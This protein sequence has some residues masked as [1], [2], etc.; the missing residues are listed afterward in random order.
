MLRPASP[1]LALAACSAVLLAACATVGAAGGAVNGTAGAGAAGL[2]PLAGA[3]FGAVIGEAPDFGIGW[4]DG[5]RDLEGP[6]RMAELGFDFTVPYVGPGS[7][8]DLA[9]YLARVEEAGLGI[10]LEVPRAQALARGTPLADYI[11]RH[12]GSPSLLGWYLF[13]EPE[14][15]PSSRPAALRKAYGEIRALDPGHPVSLVF[16]FQGLSGAYRDAMDSFWFDNYPIA[17]GSPEFAALGGGRYADRLMAA[18][19]RAASWGKP[20]VIVLQGFGEGPDGKAQFTRRLPTA[21]EARYSFY[22][23]LLAKPSSLAYW[24]WYRSRPEWIE[25]VLAPLVREFRAGFPEGLTYRSAAGLTIEGRRHFDAVVLGNGEGRLWLLLLG[26][27]SRSG[28]ATVRLPGGRLF[29]DGAAS[30]ELAPGPHEALLL[31][32]AP[33]PAAQ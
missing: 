5:I 22:A 10:W 25:G 8:E 20:L 4:Y 16:M 30:A 32:L 12:R 23:A 9:A 17:A 1:L 19:R 27:D 28:A 18:G 31:E 26:R 24:A 7:E 2:R 14:W 15:K 6:A 13:D 21:R 29:A 3:G 11:M 33:P